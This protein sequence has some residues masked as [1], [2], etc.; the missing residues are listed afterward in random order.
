VPERAEP[1]FQAGMARRLANQPPT[2]R[3]EYNARGF[4]PGCPPLRSDQEALWPGYGGVVPVSAILLFSLA[5]ISA[6]FA[7]K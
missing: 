1:R 7:G 3:R 5:C 2:R 4:D 6:T